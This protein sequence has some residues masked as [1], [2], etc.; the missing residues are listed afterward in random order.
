MLITERVKH[1]LKICLPPKFR[2]PADYMA[3]EVTMPSLTDFSAS[4]HISLLNRPNKHICF[5]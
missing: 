1:S 4:K 5:R 2:G 3:A